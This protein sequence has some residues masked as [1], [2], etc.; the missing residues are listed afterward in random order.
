MILTV[1]TN[2]IYNTQDTQT[3]EDSAASELERE[4]SVLRPINSEYHLRGR[5]E[6][7]TMGAK[8]DPKRTPTK[9]KKEKE[10]P[11][12]GG[13]DKKDNKKQVKK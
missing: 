6:H 12:K 8:K 5:I 4:K 1:R 7:R 3:T 10:E 2:S 13:K 9:E 11:R